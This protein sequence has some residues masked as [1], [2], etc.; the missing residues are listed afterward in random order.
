VQRHPTWRKLIPGTV[1]AVI[2]IVAAGF[3]LAFAR[4]GQLHG[5]TVRLYVATD[6]ARGVIRGTDVWFDG[7]MIGKVL[8][9]KI[10]PYTV[11]TARRV[12]VE[13]DVK[14]HD[15]RRIRRDSRAQIR[16]GS[17]QLGSPVVFF[18]GGTPTSPE[19]RSGDTLVSDPESALDATRAKFADFEQQIPEIRADLDTLK[20]QIFSKNSTFDTATRASDIKTA[21][22]FKVLTKSMAKRHRQAVGSLTLIGRGDLIRL[23]KHSLTTTD[24]LISLIHG[25]RGVLARMRADTSFQRSVQNTR[26]ELATIRTMLASPNLVAGRFKADSA[27]T[28]TLDAADASLRALT[29]DAVKNPDRYSPF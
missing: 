11:D 12:L 9:T 20:S 22:E 3:V 8:G 5:P 15:A 14:R 26:S 10:L 21:R 4:I 24:S 16:P 19:V 18:S 28:R 7:V 1:T 29:S 13:L 17:S 2:A 23:A 25:D 27:L 6:G